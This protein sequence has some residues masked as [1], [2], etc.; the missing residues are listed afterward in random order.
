MIKVEPYW[1]VNLSLKFFVDGV[2]VIKVEPYWNVNSIFWATIE[3][4]RNH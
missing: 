1:N 2:E 4:N 3:N